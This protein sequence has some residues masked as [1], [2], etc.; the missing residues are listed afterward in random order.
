MTP[1]SYVHE[2]IVKTRKDHECEYCYET[3][4]SGSEAQFDSFRVPRFEDDSEKQI[5]IWYVKLYFCINTSHCIETYNKKA[6]LR[7]F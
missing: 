3:I 1:E 6:E 5:G 2:K 7:P 4:K